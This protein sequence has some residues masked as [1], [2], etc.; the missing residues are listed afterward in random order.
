MPNIEAPV[1]RTFSPNDH[2]PLRLRGAARGDAAAEQWARR[3]RTFRA[4]PFAGDLVAGAVAIVV[5]A[6]IV[7]VAGLDDS[8]GL[9]DRLQLEMPATLLLL[10]GMCGLLGLYRSTTQSL[11]ERFRLRAMATLLFVFAGMLMW[12]REGLSIQLATVPLV[13]ATAL[14]LGSWIEHVI[15]ARLGR[16]GLWGIPT[17]ILGAGGNSRNLARL[18]TSQPAWGLRPV[19]FIDDGVGDGRDGSNANET[20]SRRDED[21]PL[22]TL[23]FLG[24]IEGERLDSAAEVVIVP[25]CQALPHDPDALYRLGARQILVVNQLGELPSLGL[26]I[27]HFDRYVG[28]EVGGRPRNPGHALK[29]AIDLAVALPLAL[30]TGPIIGL[31]ALAI[32][33]ADPGPVFY[34]QQRVGRYGRPIQVLKLRTMYRDAEQRLEQMLATDVAMREQWRRYFKLPRDPRILPN[35][36]NFLRRTSLDELPQLLNVIRGDMSLVGPRPFPAYHMAA[37]DPEFQALRVTVPPGL[38]GLWQ[39]SSRSNGDLGVQRAQDCFYIRNRSLWL[40][41][42]ILIATLPAVIGGQGAR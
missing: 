40:D 32:W 38:T 11:M 14:V 36:G 1:A 31:L 25:D 17:A 8:M 18:L 5:A 28:L 34:G 4:G 35:I 19:G 33:I 2:E 37:F 21:D 12:A 24:T 30:I 39:I 20:A 13:G 16:S 41:L 10:I 9:A 23:P 7:N 6:V 22:S 26:Q 27:R 15:N 29:R 3:Y 42:Y